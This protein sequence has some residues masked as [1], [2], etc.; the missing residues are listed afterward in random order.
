[1]KQITLSFLRT[2]TLAGSLLVGMG[3]CSSST[4]ADRF[5]T[6][7]GTGFGEIGASA[8]SV[9]PVTTDFGIQR[10][11]TSSS[12]ATLTVN[13]ASNYNIYLSSIGS[14]SSPHFSI[15]GTT[16]PIGASSAIEPRGSCTISV[17]F[18]PIVSGQLD[19]GLP[20]KYSGG[21]STAEYSIA[22][23]LTGT[24][25][26]DVVF[27][28]LDTVTE[29]RSR[30]VRLNWTDVANENGYALFTVESGALVFRGTAT[31][32]STTAVVTGLTANTLYSFRVRAFDYFGALEGNTRDVNA[33]TLPDPILTAVAHRTYAVNNPLLVSTPLA[34]DINNTVTASDL[35]LSYTCTFD[36][37]L[38]GGVTAGADCSTLP[39]MVLDPGF[40]GTVGAIDG[41]GIFTFTPPSTLAGRSYEINIAANDGGTIFNRSFQV[42]VRPTFKY[43]ATLLAAYQPQNADGLNPGSNSPFTATWT[44]LASTG[45]AMDATLGSGTFGSGWMGDGTWVTNPYRLV[46]DGVSGASGDRAIAGTLLNA[47]TNLLFTSWMYPTN[48]S[49]GSTAYVMGNRG[50]GVNGWAVHQ[51]ADGLYEF[52]VG[53]SAIGSYSSAVMG[54]SPIAYFKFDQLAG[55]NAY[56]EVLAANRPLANPGS[57]TL[58]GAGAYGGSTSYNF[59]GNA[60]VNIT[61]ALNFTSNWSVTAW[62]KTPLPNDGAWKTVTRGTQDHHILFNSATNE[63]GSYL[64]GSGAAWVS[65]GVDTDLLPAGWHHFAA[66]GAGA[67]I[68]YFVDGVFIVQIAGTSTDDFVAVGN[69]QAG[70]QPAR[71]IDD[72]ALFNTSLTDPQVAQIYLGGCTTGVTQ[73]AWQH[74]AGRFNG[75]LAELY[76]DGAKVC[77]YTPTGA[78]TGS[79]VNFTLGAQSDGS[80][81]WPGALGAT[82][83]YNGGIAADVT[84]NYNAQFEEYRLPASCAE[85]RAAGYT[86]DGVYAVDIDGTGAIAPMNVQCDMTEDGGGWM[87]V[88]NYLHLGGTNPALSARTTFP[89]I[90]SSVLGTDESAVAASWGHLTP[91]TLNSVPFTTTRY[92]CRSGGHGRTFHIKSSSA[93]CATYFKTGTGSCNNINA[94]YTALTGHTG[95]TPATALDAAFTNQGSSAMTEFTFYR[96]GNNHWGIRGLGGRW[97]C[98][99]FAGGSAQNTLHRLW[100]K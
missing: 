47:E 66:V 74:L 94:T 96:S 40:A 29:V 68:R 1:M 27:P 28:G 46:F 24:G 99:D 23:A 88:L 3:A 64:N 10:I 72:V 89:I 87:L 67:T 78:I 100:V 15:A 41:N 69:Y 42:N 12:P 44:N 59:S 11:Y 18:N 26:T 62:V 14:P 56:D 50:A 73:N 84:T 38:D 48:T 33:T 60:Y 81:A 98:D 43:D 95:V 55:T 76:K 71:E 20:I 75:T 79:A 2:L 5:F 49:L 45:A 93:A 51:R 32:D 4:D 80:Q 36:T 13:N 77:E 85:W 53:N 6:G 17:I 30:S 52:V 19:Y 83:I 82:Y 21:P 86:T 97:E 65:S 34:L 90:T 57:V 37:V 91:A 35:Y 7:A 9:S 16:C 58:G 31:R 61:P 63:F 92:F 22:G 8:L 54:L 39:G 70:G 25:A